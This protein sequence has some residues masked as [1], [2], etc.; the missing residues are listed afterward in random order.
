[1]LKILQV[2]YYRYILQVWEKPQLVSCFIKTLATVKVYLLCS[3][4]GINMHCG[5]SPS[6]CHP[7]GWVLAGPRATSSP[8]QLSPTLSALPV[9]ALMQHWLGPHCGDSLILCPACCLP[10]AVLLLHGIF[11]CCC[12]LRALQTG[13]KPSLKV[14]VRMPGFKEKRFKSSPTVET[15]N[16]VI[17]QLP[18]EVLVGH[19]VP[20][21]Q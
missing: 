10:Q 20:P 7:A 12:S 5:D 13:G 18:W 19:T 21:M 17:I 9:G 3:L 8:A 6:K 15:Y 2:Q 16:R 4:N 1:M 14:S 11:C